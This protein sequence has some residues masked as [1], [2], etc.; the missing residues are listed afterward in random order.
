MVVQMV[1]IE[2]K[3]KLF[4]FGSNKHYSIAVTFPKQFS[5]NI[6]LKIGEEVIIDALPDYETII[7]KRVSKDKKTE[8][9]NDE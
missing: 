3:K 6:G 2:F 8:E 4:K 1:D 9:D 5:E 7:L